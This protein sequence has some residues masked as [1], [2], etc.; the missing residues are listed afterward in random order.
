MEHSAELQ[1]QHMGHVTETWT[2]TK[3]WPYEEIVKRRESTQ[4]DHAMPYKKP[5]NIWYYI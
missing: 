5:W 1:S 2:Q 3:M 4:Y